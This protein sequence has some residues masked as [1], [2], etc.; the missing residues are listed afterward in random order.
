MSIHSE[1]LHAE[2]KRALSDAIRDTVKDPRLSALSS[3]AKVEITKDQKYA[4]VY[5]SVFDEDDAKRASSVDVLNAAAGAIARELNSRIRMRRIPTLHFVLDN[6]IEYSV[7]ISKVLSELG[8][9]R[10]SG[11][12]NDEQQ[13][14]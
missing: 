11:G 10:E 12:E 7:R 14:D 8:V 5:I 4:K 9:S 6:S 13:H 1:R 2:F 3:V